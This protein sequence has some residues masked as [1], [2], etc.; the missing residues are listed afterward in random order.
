MGLSSSQARL[1]TLT[2][3]MHDIEYKAQKL[4]AQKLK[5]A[6]DTRKVYENYL[7]ALDAVK[8]QSKVLESN[9][10]FSYADATYNRLIGTNANNHAIY[11]LRDVET[12]K[13]YVPEEYKCAYDAS[14]KTLNGFLK[15][16]NSIKSG[17]SASYTSIT[18]VE[19]LKSLSNSSGNFRLDCDLELSN[20]E[21]IQDF[22]G[23]FDGNGHT[24]TIKNG[25]N[26]L[27]YSTNGATI[28]NIAVDVNIDTTT[29]YT[30]GLIS[31]AENTTVENAS[32]S[33]NI[34][35]GL[36][37]G[38]LIG[39]IK[40]NAEIS[41]CESSANVYCAYV[42][43]NNGYGP[44]E[45]FDFRTYTGGFIGCAGSGSSSTI[46]ISDCAS[47]G[48]VKSEYWYIG[49]FTGY[50]RGTITMN[51]C[52][53]YSNV[54][55]NCNGNG[56]NFKYIIETNTYQKVSTFNGETS[57]NKIITVNNC[58]AMG[59]ASAN[60]DT[61]YSYIDDFSWFHPTPTFNNFYSTLDSST[62]SSGTKN[63]YTP[64]TNPSSYPNLTEDDIEKA[65][66]M[67]LILDQTKGGVCVPEEMT[68][69]VEWFT[70]IVNSGNALISQ[71]DI[72]NEKEYSIYDVSVAIDTNLREVQDEQYLRKAE[73]QYEADMRRID[74]KDR[75]YDIDLAALDNERNAIKS[76]M[77]TLKTVAK[78][79]VERTFKLFS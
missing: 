24:I 6:N 76:E 54:L 30:A 55:A 71:V 34:K 1:L 23:N 45:E 66:G 40:G 14:N 38:G 17:E 56:D 28:K 2:G 11:I 58:N 70:N 62:I 37:V 15:T 31:I 25:D 49:G 61:R 59:T 16:L 52:E 42:S 57:T 68:N 8:I 72:S 18:S 13:A 3:R 7:N 67:F 22:K 20:W 41:N 78:D 39:Y 33:G 21:G 47:K 63:I 44:D 4:E 5:L 19:Q 51:N 46:T 27:F 73:A 32:T 77:E 43:P 79:N 50:L 26:G 48:D 53:S 12:G 60:G 9:G 74:M 64:D 75:K 29:N 36:V 65:V 10:T 69:S 35:S